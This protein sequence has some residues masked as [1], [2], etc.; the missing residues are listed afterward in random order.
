MQSYNCEVTLF[1]GLMLDWINI[2]GAYQ[3]FDGCCQSH[4]YES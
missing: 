2:I 4:C 1:E 3:L